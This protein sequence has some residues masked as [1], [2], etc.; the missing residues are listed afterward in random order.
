MGQDDDLDWSIEEDPVDAAEGDNTG[1]TQDPVPQRTRIDWRQWLTWRPTAALIGVML[2]ALALAVGATWWQGETQRVAFEAHVRA[3]D[4]A[5]LGRDRNLYDQ[6]MAEAPKQAPMGWLYRQVVLFVQGVAARPLVWPA[7]VQNGPATLLESRAL[8]TDVVL[9]KVA[10]RYTA[11]AGSADPTWQF[12]TLEVYSRTAESTWQRAPIG[13]LPERIV[14]RDLL[15]GA[16]RWT[17]TD[18]DAETVAALAPLVRANFERLCA[19]GLPCPDAGQLEVEIVVGNSPVHSPDWRAPT[20]VAELLLAESTSAEIQFEGNRAQAVL[21]R[22]SFAET[23]MPSGPAELNALAREL[24]IELLGCWLAILQPDHGAVAGALALRLAASAGVINAADAAIEPLGIYTP[25]ELWSADASSVMPL[26]ETLA[27]LG[28]LPVADAAVHGAA[29]WSALTEAD[30]LDAWLNQALGWTDAAERLAAV[31]PHLELEVVASGPV[32]GILAC[33]D[34][35]FRTRW[36]GWLRDTG[37]STPLLEAEQ[38]RRLDQTANPTMLSPDGSRL[39]IVIG[40]RVHVLDLVA[41]KD[42]AL[43]DVISGNTWQVRWWGNAAVVAL[44]QP[45]GN[46]PQVL[47]DLST[48]PPRM[49]TLSEVFD[50]Y[51]L[52]RSGRQVLR[53]MLAGSGNSTL[54]LINVFDNVRVSQPADPS[55]RFVREYGLDRFWQMSESA[56]SDTL[57]VSGVQLDPVRGAGP[58]LLFS[59]SAPGG[60]LGVQGLAID[61]VHLQAAISYSEPDVSRRVTI[62]YHIGGIKAFETQRIEQVTAGIP[63]IAFSSDGSLLFLT[64][65]SDTTSGVD[66][67]SVATGEQVGSLADV[68]PVKLDDGITHELYV[69]SRGLYLNA[70]WARSSLLTESYPAVWNGSDPPRSVGPDGCWLSAARYRP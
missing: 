62:V 53:L 8:S 21:A 41:G 15:D 42:I 44:S 67:F 12:V 20:D 70:D 16:V 50:P 55:A 25:T 3:V 64:N 17:Y 30:T 10:R 47:V 1:P 27:L 66:A 35:V 52:S 4:Q 33:I 18:W 49:T 54:D 7:V 39:L 5:Y 65:G 48:D 37:S 13:D 36:T 23:G 28:K 38:A 57:V 46:A 32:D 9:A 63:E 2:G 58:G 56:T 22:L 59:V 26:R 34:T 61:S 40:D 31:S 24:T 14:N 68:D 43:P 19:S 45:A 29:L 60:G 69:N 11:P 6:L 51:L